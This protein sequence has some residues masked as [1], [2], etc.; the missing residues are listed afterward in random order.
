MKVAIIHPWLPQ[1][2]TRFFESLYSICRE[3]GVDLHIF[4]GETPR[5][6][7][8][9]NDSATTSVATELR[10]RF[11]QVRNRTL[12]F[13][14]RKVVR[15]EGPFD[16]LILE[17][18]IR[19]L[20]TYSYLIDKRVS[21]KVA[22]WGHGKTYT[23]EK[24][25]LEEWVKSFVT[26]RGTWFFG[27]TD[28]G[29][30]AVVRNGF[31]AERT[32]VVQNSIDTEGLR[33]SLDEISAAEVHTFR[34]SRGLGS[35]T[36]LY[37]GGV[38]EAKRIPFLLDCAAVIGSTDPEFSLL[39]AGS[40][41]MIDYVRDRA[42]REAWIVPLGSTFGREKALAMRSAQMLMIPGRVGLVAVDS[43]VAGLPII[44]TDWPLHAPEFEY[45]EDGRTCVIADDDVDS[46][47]RAVAELFKD[48]VQLGDMRTQCLLEAPRFSATEMAERF[49]DGILK[50]VQ[51]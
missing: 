30:E 12:S 4:Y 2:R 17:Q 27:Y 6:W 28:G 21:R 32:T 45:L 48:G 22:F 8:A 43:L 31:D 11:F 51:S 34:S 36:A 38:D 24:G 7:S 14:D 33:A 49:F 1:Y 23:A 39:I 40:G 46:Y 25:R 20:E 29:T 16:L 19:N 37:L 9:R 50:A 13:K 35:H 44:T 42:S 15:E 18:A 41:S 26:R 3:N 10:T 47:A 5:E